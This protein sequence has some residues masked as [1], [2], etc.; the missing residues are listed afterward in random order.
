[1]KDTHN[2]NHTRW[3]CKYHVVFIP[4]AEGTILSLR[5]CRFFREALDCW[6]WTEPRSFSYGVSIGDGWRFS[7]FARTS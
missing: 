6:L 1:M 4:N 5:P 3:E 2:L 7:F